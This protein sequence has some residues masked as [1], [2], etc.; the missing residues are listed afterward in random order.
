M[1][2]PLALL[3]TVGRER[4]SLPGSAA[5][6]TAPENFGF[7]FLSKCCPGL[8]PTALFR[9]HRRVTALIRATGA[10]SSLNCP[11]LDAVRSEPLT[12][13]STGAII[14]GIPN[15]CGHHRDVPRHV[16]F[17]DGLFAHR[18]GIGTVGWHHGAARPFGHVWPRL[19]LLSAHVH[20]Q[21]KV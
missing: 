16:Q 8:R 12:D 17:G 4:V 20:P 6:D 1:A 15:R 9:A 14:R 18:W 10:S 21:Q 19:K 13:E 7:F 11:S 3:L 2:T 5:R